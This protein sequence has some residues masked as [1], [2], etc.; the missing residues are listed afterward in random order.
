MELSFKTRLSEPR[1]LDY[2]HHIIQPCRRAQTR[3]KYLYSTNVGST[4]VP[5][6]LHK[7]DVLIYWWEQGEIESCEPQMCNALW[8]CPL[9]STGNLPSAFCDNEDYFSVY[10]RIKSKTENQP[11][12]LALPPCSG[13][14]LPS[15]EWVSP[16]RGEPGQEPGAQTPHNH[17]KPITTAA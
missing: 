7:G 14:Q 1:G 10:I 16:I 3:H 9:R 4:W 15:Q 17:G 13:C 5:M 11:H 6:R 2:N 12:C 8:L